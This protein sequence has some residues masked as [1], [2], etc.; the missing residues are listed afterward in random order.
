[1]HKN[2][3]S[4]SEIQ[5]FHNPNCSKAKKV[6]AYA[7]SISNAVNTV[8][9]SITRGTGTLWENLLTKLK[10]SPKQ[11]LDKSSPYYQENIRGR[12][13][14]DRDWINVLIKSP[15]LIRGPIVVRGS[16]ALILDNPTDIYKM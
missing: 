11:L 15:E 1:M 16:K 5:I 13:F 12:N 2:T 3:S 6:L 14:E 7:K 10:K 8:D 4:S 9:L